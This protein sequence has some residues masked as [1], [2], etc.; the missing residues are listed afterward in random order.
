MRM[1]EYFRPSAAA[2]SALTQNN[3]GGN[4]LSALEHSAITAISQAPD[5]N[6]GSQILQELTVLEEKR[7]E[8]MDKKLEQDILDN[9]D[10]NFIFNKGSSLSTG[11]IDQDR[12]YSIMNK[13]KE[14]AFKQLQKGSKEIDYKEIVEYVK[15]EQGIFADEFRDTKVGQSKL[16]L[17][18]SLKEIATEPETVSVA[19][20]E[21]E[22]QRKW[23]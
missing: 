5:A 8:E 12:L 9:V 23:D 17:D 4:D 13:L 20:A 21:E 15:N 3:I 1:A 19:N 18:K 7:R 2:M 22:K 10:I 14:L 16:D 11:L 6:E